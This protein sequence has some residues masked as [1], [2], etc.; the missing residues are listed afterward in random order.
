MGTAVERSSM[1]YA[2][3]SFQAMVVAAIV[4]M[5]AG[6]AHALEWAAA[7]RA[8]AGAPAK[9]RRVRVLVGAGVGDA[10]ADPDSD[11][12]DPITPSVDADLGGA[13]ETTGET[14]E[15]RLRV[16]RFG[17]IGTSFMVVA[18]LIHLA[19]V[20]MRGI[21]ADRVPWAN[22]HEFTA[23]S[24]AIGVIAYLV[25]NTKWHLRWLGLFMAFAASI[26]LGLAVT[27]F[28]VDVS[29][30]VP[31]LHS[32]WFMFH[33]G[34]ASASGAAFTLGGIASILYLV[35]ERG[36]RRGTLRG[37][38]AKMPSAQTID[39]F[40]YRCAAFAFPLYTFVIAAGAIWAQYAWGRYWGWD[41]KETWS[42]I[43]WAIYAAYLHARSTAG[44]RGV[45]AA[46]ISIVG[47][48][49]FW[50]NFVGINLFVQGLHSYAK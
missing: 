7:H 48:L 10:A 9:R 1:D 26:G 42:L 33:I 25:L 46:V 11:E 16:D 41:P 13:D 34:A 38:L 45:R 23:S 5:F 44:W 36:E 43:T 49:V 31:S 15:D 21:A 28:Y 35:R 37:Y 2:Q 14:R 24:L 19:A 4:Y 27:V 30:L 22:M 3:M 29:P 20:V 12:S 32:A 8:V 17:R 18:L 6:A 50:W 39:T 40:A 47:A